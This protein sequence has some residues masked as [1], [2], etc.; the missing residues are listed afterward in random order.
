MMQIEILTLCH[1]YQRRLCWDFTSLLNQN[2]TPGLKIIASVC[3]MEYNG[4]PTTEDVA[5]HFNHWAT[6]DDVDFKVKVM[7]YEPKDIER[8]AHRGYTRNDQVKELDVN[9]DWVLFSDCDMVYSP[10]FFAELDYR[11]S[12]LQPEMIPSVICVGRMSNDAQLVTNIIDNYAEEYPMRVKDVNGI[13]ELSK[14][15]MKNVGA[16]YFQLVRKEWLDG[17]YVAEGTTRD[18]HMFKKGLNPRSDIQFRKRYERRLYWD[19]DNI[20][21]HLNHLRDPDV[22]GHVEVQR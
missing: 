20:Q 8:F 1:N 9:T 17:Y 18:K 5:F 10:N 12:E 3:A 15:K 6:E 7:T 16:G 4:D 21:Y 19:M 11:L 13:A 14:R 22:E 2:Y